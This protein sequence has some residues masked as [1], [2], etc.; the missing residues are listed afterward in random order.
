MREKLISKI[1]EET[2]LWIAGLAFFVAMLG[3]VLAFTVSLPIG[4]WIGVT[5]ALLGLVGIAM[6]FV[7][8][9]REIFN[10]DRS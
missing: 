3:G 4:Y 10:I 5:G 6:H 8:N 7:R 9:W 1:S 2:G